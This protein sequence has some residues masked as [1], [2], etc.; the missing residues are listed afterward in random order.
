MDRRRFRFSE[1]S[2][3]FFSHSLL[4]DRR[5]INVKAFTSGLCAAVLGLGLIGVAGC[6]PDN[7]A[8]G[9]KLGKEAGNPGAENPNAAKPDGKPVTTQKEMYERTQQQMKNMPGAKKN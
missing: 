1:G 5:S 2:V 4:L 3:A 8:E 9:V 6:G 7:E